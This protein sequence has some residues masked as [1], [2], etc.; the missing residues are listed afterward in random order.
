MKTLS[1]AAAAVIAIS[2]LAAE[3]PAQAVVGQK[4]PALTLA[5]SL[6]KSRSLAEFAGKTVVLEWWN[7]ECPFVRKHY[8]S[9]NMQKLQ[10]EWT[11]KGVVWLTVSS[12]AA[13]KQG[14]VDGARAAALMH[15]KGGAQTAVLLDHDGK[16]GK[17]YG[18]KTTP[19]LFVI[20]KDG[21]VAY[22]GGIDDKPSADPED[23][24][25]ATNYVTAA[26]G[27]LLAGKPVTTRTSQPYGCSVKY[28]D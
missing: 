25:G 9:G 16:V 23:I 12:S 18:A 27:E 19:H 14:H 20:G 13:G 8:G 26:L 3:A 4:A 15:E 24:A 5:D 1:F 2:A 11:G 21:N 17:A 6:G 7:H 22:A 10:K 28:A